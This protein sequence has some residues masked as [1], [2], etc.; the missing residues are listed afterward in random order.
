[1]SHSFVQENWIHVDCWVRGS[2]TYIYFSSEEETKFESKIAKRWG[3]NVF[4][5]LAISIFVFF[6]DDVAH[7]LLYILAGTMLELGHTWP[8]RHARSVNQGLVSATVTN[9][10]SITDNLE[11]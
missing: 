2:P 4:Y 6:F 5:V 7:H 8:G 9:A 3:E 11:L 1:M 10:V